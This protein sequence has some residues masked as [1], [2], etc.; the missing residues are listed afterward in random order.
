M[1][2]EFAVLQNNGALK[3]TYEQ[4]GCKRETLT[5]LTHVKLN[6]YYI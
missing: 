5:V 2:L 4:E 3:G 6:Q 1:R